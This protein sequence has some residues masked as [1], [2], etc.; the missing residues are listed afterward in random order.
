MNNSCGTLRY[1]Q[2]R[3]FEAFW[4][5][6]IMFHPVKYSSLSLDYFREY[7]RNPTA[8]GSPRMVAENG[9]QSIHVHELPENTLTEF[10]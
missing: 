10:P 9:T 5:T 8:F 4:A 2:S 3:Y 1:Y 7:P 6:S